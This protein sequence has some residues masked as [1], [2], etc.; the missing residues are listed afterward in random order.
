MNEEIEKLIKINQEL[1]EKIKIKNKEIN[2]YKAREETIKK[3]NIDLENE[4]DTLNFLMKEKVNEFENYK[5]D[6]LQSRNDL[7][8]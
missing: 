5:K 7:K 4:R 3:K 8:K 2:E 1:E 6:I